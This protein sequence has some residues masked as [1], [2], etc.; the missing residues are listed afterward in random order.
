MLLTAAAMAGLAM[1]ANQAGAQVAVTCGGTIQKCPDGKKMFCNR[2]KACKNK[3]AKVSK[4]CDAPVC[5]TERKSK[6]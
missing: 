5:I 4:Y 1:S 6:D 2:W 3:N